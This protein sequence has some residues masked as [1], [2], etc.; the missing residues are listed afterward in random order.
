MKGS[1]STR[2]RTF[3]SAL[4]LFSFTFL[5][6]LATISPTA[7][8]QDNQLV[9]TLTPVAGPPGTPVGVYG[10]GFSGGA[11]TISFNQQQVATA[12][13]EMF[14]RIDGIFVVPSVSQGVYTV[15]ATTSS[16][17]IATATFTVTAKGS[18]TSN[19]G[20]NPTTGTNTGTTTSTETNA[21]TGTA[22]ITLSA[23]QGNVGKSIT[24][25]GS[26]FGADSFITINFAT[27]YVAATT[28]DSSGNFNVAFW[29]PMESNGFYS[30][31]ASNSQGVYASQT[32]TVTSGPS[33]SNG[34]TT[35]TTGAGFWT[36]I[37]TIAVGLVVAV[38]VIVPVT[39]VYMRRSKP[40]TVIAEQPVVQPQTPYYP[41]A[42]P[43][44]SSNS[45]YNK[46]AGIASRYDQFA[47]YGRPT[48]RGTQTPRPYAT[49][50]P[51]PS[52]NSSTYSAVNAQMPRRSTVPT[53]G[54]QNTVSS[55]STNT[56][57]CR[58]CKQT[59][60][61]DYNICPYCKKKTR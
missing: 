13:P 43:P 41:R 37:N 51:R 27:T 36:G 4:T 40:E 5:I 45:P 28:A 34:S 6:A 46:P 48:N 47:S 21:P 18:P 10:L 55:Q 14:G 56:V 24:I 26:G 20:T 50:M 29:V 38:A 8:A 2:R 23:T 15:T 53:Y 60:R 19:T 16:G 61:A 59:V 25:K 32:F 52:S 35:G 57:T 9:I 31:S 1:L 11:V 42:P 3:L 44:P 30:V 39:F 12:H 17:S 33:G 58:H 54:Q 22:S 49:S 7:I